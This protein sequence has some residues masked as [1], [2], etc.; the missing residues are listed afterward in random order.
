[1][2]T[3]SH[4]RDMEPL[5]QQKLGEDYQ[6]EVVFK[7]GVKLK[8][9]VE[10]ATKHAS[11]L[12]P[13]DWLVVMGGSND[14]NTPVNELSASIRKLL[15][16]SRKCK[17]IIN[18]VMRR[19]YGT[20]SIG[21]PLNKV[22]KQMNRMIH[23][24]VNECLDKCS[25]NIRLNFLDKKISEF[26]LRND[27]LHLNKQGKQVLCNSILHFLPVTILNKPENLRTGLEK[28]L[29]K[30][31]K[32][33]NTETASK[34]DTFLDK[35]ISVMGRRRT[36][37]VRSASLSPEKQDAGNQAPIKSPLHQ[38]TPAQDVDIDTTS[39]IL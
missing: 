28:W 37:E 17:L 30:G 2:V 12:S 29:T 18:N 38:P 6:V 11:H 39:N 23:T 14:T 20:N 31:R 7:S 25:A 1:M 16:L 4:G 36:Q 5:L 33:S 10:K 27:G 34:E 13:L 3:D 19:S 8:E 22:I 24:T 32:M 21:E 35:W 9:I 15:P 26:H